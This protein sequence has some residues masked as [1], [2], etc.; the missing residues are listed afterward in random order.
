MLLTPPEDTIE[1]N[2]EVLAMPFK[3]FFKDPEFVE[4]KE[5]I[6]WN[7]LCNVFKSELRNGLF[8]K[9]YG[10]NSIFLKFQLEKNAAEAPF[11]L[12]LN[13]FWS[14]WFFWSFD[15]IYSIMY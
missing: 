7:D 12:V 11:I 8:P 6:V 9:F 4:R 2:S 15:L 13:F 5:D 3:N 10:N 1:F 14:N